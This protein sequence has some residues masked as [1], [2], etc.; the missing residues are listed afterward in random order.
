ML[1]RNKR[2]V[3]LVLYAINEQGIS[4]KV[5]ILLALPT[6]IIVQ[7]CTFTQS[8]R[9]HIRINLIVSVNGGP[10]MLLIL[11]KRIVLNLHKARVSLVTLPPRDSKDQ[12]LRDPVADTV[13]PQSASRRECGCF[14]EK[15]ACGR[16]QRSRQVTAMNCQPA[17]K[18]RFRAQERVTEAP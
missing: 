6:I 16:D 12:T 5:H 8:D 3:D 18:S 7:L 13:V 9:R 14:A 15:V 11:E 4:I 1:P 17:M 10:T 2:K